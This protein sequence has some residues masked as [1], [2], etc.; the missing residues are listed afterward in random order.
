MLFEPRDYVRHILNE[1][2]YL[3]NACKRLSTKRFSPTYLS[4]LPARCGRRAIELR[5][6]IPDD[7]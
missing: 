3:L 4:A 6:T 5:V 7:E 2:D 1:A